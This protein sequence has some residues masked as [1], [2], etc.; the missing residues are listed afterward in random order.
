M[1]AKPNRLRQNKDIEEVFKRG[2]GKRSQFFYLKW[3][4]NTPELKMNVV[5]SAKTSKKSVTRHLLKRQVIE[6]FRTRLAA[7]PKAHYSLVV[8]KEAV[9]QNF[10]VLKQDLLNLLADFKKNKA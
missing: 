8:Q 1:L 6:I 2:R 3:L 4:A 9:N 10:S 5:V 7:L